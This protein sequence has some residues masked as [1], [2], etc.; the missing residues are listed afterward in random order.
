[1]SQHSQNI[2]DK[3]IVQEDEIDLVELTKVI[4]SKRTFI[5]KV[6]GIFVILGLVIA[7]T[8]KVEYKASC[9]LM[10]ETQEGM[11]NLGGLG[12]L[13]GLAG[14]DLS[15]LGGSGVLSPELY[16]EIVKSAP[17]L[18]KLINTPVYFEKLDTTLTS[19][20]YFKEIDNPS[21]FGYVAEY[22]I[23]LP[24][25]IKK[26]FSS[27]EEAKLQDYDMIRFSKED[28]EI[29]ERFADR[30]SVSVDT[31]T[32]TI[33][34]SAEMP[35]AVAAAQ[36]ADQLVKDL[37]ERIIAYKSS[38]AQINLEFIEERFEEA[39]QEYQQ[40]Q[41]QLARFTDSNRNI[42]NAIIQNEYERLQNEMNIAFE[43]YKGLATQL[44]QAKIKVKEDTPVLTELEPVKVPE[45]KSKP[46]RGLILIG[47]CFVGVLISIS[48]IIAKKLINE[49]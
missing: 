3:R 5:F 46:K 49:R 47:L 24:G 9:K 38:K 48:M 4:W 44:E 17:F 23:G 19:F 36:V 12:G 8:T 18:D 22:T 43:V 28:W 37:S 29:M 13:A 14:F 39:K 31:K 11:P 21:L 26:L 25:K 27:S 16:P 42:T 20:E 7:F 1:M 41:E 6:T 10:P 34:V 15:G 32:G 33:G 30:L 35:D 45:D 40:K 2:E